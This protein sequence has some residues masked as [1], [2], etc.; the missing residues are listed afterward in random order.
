[1]VKISPAQICQSYNWR[2]KM[3]S[4]FGIP[5][6]TNEQRAYYFCLNNNEIKI[7]NK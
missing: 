1:M 4:L 2:E 6:G 5:K 7:F 3:V